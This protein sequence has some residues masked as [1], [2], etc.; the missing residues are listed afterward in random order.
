METACEAMQAAVTYG[1][2]NLREKA[3][4]YIEQ[5]TQVKGKK[6]YNGKQCENNGKC[7]GEKQKKRVTGKI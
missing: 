4:K 1:Q 7:T 5:N 3:M 2:D 6:I